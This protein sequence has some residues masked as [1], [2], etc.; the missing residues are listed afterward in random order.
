MKADAPPLSWSVWQRGG[1]CLTVSTE[2]ITLD[3]SFPE[4][5]GTVTVGRD[6]PPVS[7]FRRVID[8]GKPT[9]RWV[10]LSVRP[11]E[12]EPPKVLGVFAK[13]PAP[14]HRF[15]YFPGKPSEVRSDHP[16]ASLNGLKVDHVTLELAS[17]MS[18]SDEHVA[19]LGL[20]PG[21]KSRGHR[22]RGSVH[23]GLLHPWFSLLLRGFEDYR[24]LPARYR[25]T[26]EVPTA[27]RG[28]RIRA[29]GPGARTPAL[30]FPAP[31]GDPSYYQLDVW[32]GRGPAWRER[33][34]L[35]LPWSTIPSVAE[36]PQHPPGLFHAHAHSFGDDF[37]IITLL[38][39]PAGVLHK[40][41]LVH[42]TVEPNEPPA[43]S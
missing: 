25:Y 36:G 24:D 11:A 34:C 38:S 14:G 13:T 6:D 27:D 2:P 21:E 4:G 15:L 31:P 9:G 30:V 35:V 18:R 41:C 8:S 26:F 3:L 33:R 22:R 10:I 19:V 12:D 28:R 42:G 32:A 43:L 17:D 16:K 20:P 29:F 7:V 37:G 39:R 5:D 23:P 40:P 1:V